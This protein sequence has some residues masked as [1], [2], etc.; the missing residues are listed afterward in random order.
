MRRLVAIVATVVVGA[1]CGLVG[2]WAADATMRPPQDPLPTPEP[3]TIRA[4]EGTVG[5]RLSVSASASWVAAASVRAPASGVVT[6]LDV[7]SGDL[8][9]A[10]DQLVTVDLQPVFV[11]PGR[12][13][14]FRDLR[15]GSQGADVQQLNAYLA[16]A[17]F[18]SGSVDGSY[19]A[20]TSRAVSRWKKATGQ[21]AGDG[22][23]LGTVTFVA[24]LPARVRL[25][26]A[27]GDAVGAADVLAE[28]VGPAPSFEIALTDEQADMV[29]ARAQVTVLGPESQEWQ[30]VAAGRRDDSAGAVLMSLTGV[31]G[32][33][34]CGTQCGVLPVS[35]TTSLSG[36]IT[37]VPETRGIVVPAA[38]VTTRPDGSRVIRTAAGEVLDVEVLEAADGQVVL[39]GVPAG[40][41]VLLRDAASP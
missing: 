17:G 25:E 8:V 36:Q 19:D 14:A 39:D 21:P 35:D 6:T 20:G 12:V 27:V 9:Q 11:L 32:A 15:P 41:E 18:L 13:P 26:V 3:V 16:A 1:T 28:A 23:A 40:T 31:D 4:E 37:L 10:G 7:V 5:R 24:Q 30:A 2:W 38:A 29:P 22:V 33:A 34:V